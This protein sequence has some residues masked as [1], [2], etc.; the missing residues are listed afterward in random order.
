LA[1]WL[2]GWLAGWL[3]GWLA[4][5]L[6][7]WLAWRACTAPVGLQEV[8][9]TTGGFNEMP[10]QSSCAARYQ[11][12]FAT[13]LCSFTAAPTAAELILMKLGTPTLN[14]G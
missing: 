1:G 14:D 9:T 3:V 11:R 12:F 8:R 2:V 13:T 5:W 4:G 7:G 6:V 10:S